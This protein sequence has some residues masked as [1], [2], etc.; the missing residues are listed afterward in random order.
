MERKWYIK[1]NTAEG[2][3]YSIIDLTEDELTVVKRFCK[4]EVISD[5]YGGEDFIYDQIAFNNKAD[6]IKAINEITKHN[7]QLLSKILTN[8]RVKD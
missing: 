4:A 8:M 1:E 3:N 2:E 5:N 7:S 6:A